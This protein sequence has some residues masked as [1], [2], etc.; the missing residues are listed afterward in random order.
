M[1][2]PRSAWI[3]GRIF[4]AIETAS[5]GRDQSMNGRMRLEWREMHGLPRAA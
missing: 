3:T 4:P 5:F 1:R 2:N